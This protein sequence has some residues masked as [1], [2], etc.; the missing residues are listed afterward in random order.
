MQ[1]FRA[2]ADIFQPVQQYAGMQADALCRQ[3]F[4]QA[5][6]QVMVEAAKRQA[7]AIEQID[8]RAQTLEDAGEFHADIAA[9]DHGHAPRQVRQEERL[10]RDLRPR[11]PAMTGGRRRQ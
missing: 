9:A 7:L 6:A 5:V 1:P 3:G 11:Y 2:A 8:L 10:V 4:R